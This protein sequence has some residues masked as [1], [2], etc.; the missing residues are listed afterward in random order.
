LLVVLFH[1]PEVLENV[2]LLVAT[3]MDALQHPNTINAGSPASG[4]P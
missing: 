2:A 4:Y 3:R 1:R